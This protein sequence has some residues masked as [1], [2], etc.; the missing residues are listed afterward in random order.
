M[1]SRFAC[2]LDTQSL[3]TAFHLS[4]ESPVW[5]PSRSVTPDQPAPVI[6]AG[7][8]PAHRQ[9]D[10]M[11]WGLVPH[12]AKDMSRRPYNARAETV[13]TSG[14]FWAAYRARRCIIP[15]TGFHESARS[16]RWLSLPNNQIM[17]L[18]AI[19]ENWEHEGDI[20]HSFAI[21]TAPADDHTRV[22]GR[23]LPVLIAPQDRETWLTGPR[24]EASRLLHAPKPHKMILAD[25]PMAPRPDAST[26]SKGTKG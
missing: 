3:R 9:L 17:G 19:W 15:A 14:M 13:A 18:A 25:E 11:L 6:R 8:R 23:R 4:G 2:D 24:D 7:N 5:L 22:T 20:L 16:P 26:P 12:W 1:T 21:V 10:L